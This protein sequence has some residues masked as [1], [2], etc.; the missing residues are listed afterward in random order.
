MGRAPPPRRRPAGPR[1]SPSSAPARAAL[2]SRPASP[3]SSCTRSP[4]AGERP[5]RPASAWSSTAPTSCV[6]ATLRVHGG[7]FALLEHDDQARVLDGWGAALGGFCRARRR[8]P[9]RLVRVGRAGV[10]GRAPRLRPRPARRGADS[11]PRRLPGPGRPG[12]PAHLRP[13]DPRDRDR[14]PSPGSFRPRRRRRR[15]RGRRAPRGAPPVHE[16]PRASRVPRRSAPRPRR[17]GPGRAAPLRPVRRAAARDPP[18]PPGRAGADGV[19]PQPRR[20]SRST[21]GGVTSA[22]TRRCTA[23]SGSRSGH[24]SKSPATGWPPCCCTPAGSAP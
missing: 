8:H 17:A 24:A 11:H 20:R 3:A 6:S 14:R 22:S 18:R 10:T 4:A 12:R 16:P 2:T 5:A 19:A 15:G 7:A 23:A 13:R 21:P 1:A 9:G